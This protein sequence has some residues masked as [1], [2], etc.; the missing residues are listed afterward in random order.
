MHQLITPSLDCRRLGHRIET[1]S[2]AD[3]P[4]RYE[5][6]YVCSLGYEMAMTQLGDEA[7]A[8]AFVQDLRRA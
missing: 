6:C 7:Q 2:K 3:G 5:Y 1:R 8:D 4:G